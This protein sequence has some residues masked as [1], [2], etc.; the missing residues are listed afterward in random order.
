MNGAASAPTAT[1]SRSLETM[2]NPDRPES[3]FYTTVINGQTVVVERVAPGDA[4]G[5]RGWNH[6]PV[7]GKPNISSDDRRPRR[8]RQLDRGDQGPL[9]FDERGQLEQEEEIRH[10]RGSRACGWKGPPSK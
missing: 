4:T 2:T 1:G 9:D 3:T 8:K 6:Y 7:V 5:C 10:T